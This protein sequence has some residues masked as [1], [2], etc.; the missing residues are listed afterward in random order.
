MNSRGILLIPILLWLVAFHTASG[1]SPLSVKPQPDGDGVQATV[2]PARTSANSLLEVLDSQ[3]RCVRTVF[4][5]MFSDGQSFAVGRKD[6]LAPGAYRL[7][8]REGIKL[9]YECSLPAP[10]GE[11][12][13]NPSDVQISAQG[14]YVLDS[15]VPPPRR[16]PGEPAPK[17]GE[18]E[19]P[20]NRSTICR[21]QMDG[22]PATFR[23]QS[24]IEPYKGGTG[25]RSFAV[26]ADGLIY[27]GSGSHHTKIISA[28]GVPMARII[29]GWDNNPHGPKCTPW[30]NSM[31]LGGNKRMYLTNTYGNM[32]IYDYSKNGFEGA[33]GFGK[34]PGYIGMDRCVT[35]DLDGAVYVITRAALLQRFDDTGQALEP[36]YLTSPKIKMAQPVGPSASGGLIWV[37]AHGP[38][39]G[40][41]WDSGGGGEVLLFW[42]NGQALVLVDRF[43]TPGAGKDDKL[44][45]MNPTSTAMTP[46][47]LALCVAEDGQAN[48]EGPSGAARIRKFR[49]ASDQS[50][51]VS[52]EIAA[53]KPAK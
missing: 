24:C 39:F 31:A 49:I 40:P 48:T 16:K 34:L 7:R 45:F 50:E 9:E 42:D 52:F 21:F 43:G 47:H 10:S 8:F 35:A 38:G 46:D 51:E 37:A 18:D 33:L 28:I 11:K 13:V 25:I 44:E 30:V 26:D 41:F 17:P 27:I 2:T 12:W 4:A 32:K 6:R 3:G 29:G 14:I 23:S 53:P 22:K 5:G 20:G 15:G 1:G 36:K 19:S